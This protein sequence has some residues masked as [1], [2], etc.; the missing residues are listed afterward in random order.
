LPLETV[1]KFNREFAGEEAMHI[2]DMAVLEV[3]SSDRLSDVQVAIREAGFDIDTSQKRMAESVGFV[4]TLVTL[5]FT[6]ISLSMVGVAAVNIGH[7]FFIIIYERKREIGL[8]RALGAS[9]ADIRSMIFGEAALVGASGG[10]AGVAA[11]VAACALV[12]LLARQLLPEF[13][14]KPDQFFAYPGWMLASGM[15]LA[16]VF[17]LVGAF[18]PANRAARFDPAS[19]LSGR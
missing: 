18:S 4:V 13:P 2:Y 15:I 16:V 19:T 5:G 11:G 10:A 12:N 9:K 7:T 6:L 8:L 14:F 1:R 17:C 3:S